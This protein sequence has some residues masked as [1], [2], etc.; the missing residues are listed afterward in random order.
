MLFVFESKQY[1]MNI[2]GNFEHN[3]EPDCCDVS[4]LLGSQLQW[5]D[6]YGLFA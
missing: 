3:E 2:L 6:N 1:K 5:N 4:V